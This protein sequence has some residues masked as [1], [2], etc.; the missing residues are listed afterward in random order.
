M[1]HPIYIM[2]CTAGNQSEAIFTVFKIRSETCWTEAQF[3][4]NLYMVK[5][6]SLPDRPIFA[7]QDPRSGTYF[8]DCF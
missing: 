3:C 2:V 1:L 7:G 5:M 4:Q 6:E 8:E